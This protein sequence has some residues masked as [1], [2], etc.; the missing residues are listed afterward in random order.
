[1]TPSHS[2]GNAAL[3]K[4]WQFTPDRAGDGT[5]RARVSC[6]RGEQLSA[7]AAGGTRVVWLDATTGVG[8]VVTRARPSGTCA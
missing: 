5:H 1:R 7:A 4:L 3:A 6:N 2:I 8:D